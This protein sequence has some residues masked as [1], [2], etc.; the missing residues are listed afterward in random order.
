MGIVSLETANTAPL[1][2]TNRY[3]IFVR[4][5]FLFKRREISALVGAR[6]QRESWNDH[7]HLASFALR[8]AADAG[9]ALS[10]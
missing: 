9:F 1:R 4:E 8:R 5:F 10:V 3:L 6:L 2:G 7:L